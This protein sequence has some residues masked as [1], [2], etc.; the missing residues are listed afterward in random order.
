MYLKRVCI[1]SFKSISYAEIELSP[2][3]NC[4]TG[5]NGVGKS[6]FLD[7]ILFALTVPLKQLRVECLKDLISK[8]GSNFKRYSK[9][10]SVTLTFCQRKGTDQHVLTAKVIVND[11]NE[12]VFYQIDNKN[13]KKQEVRRWLKEVCNI[14]VDFEDNSEMYFNF[15]IAQNIVT[16]IPFLSNENKW[17]FILN[18]AG[19]IDWERNKNNAYKEINKCTLQLNLIQSN[20]EKLDQMLGKEK[21][22]I[23]KLKYMKSM[24]A[25]FAFSDLR[26]LFYN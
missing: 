4:I 23:V 21:D 12:H 22:L 7:A 5:P 3:L 10:T 8:S 9:S 24:Y 18:A 17:K 13:K 15:V 16:R 26:Y 6:N 11:Q 20:I 1:N 19:T 2:H 25:Q 14:T